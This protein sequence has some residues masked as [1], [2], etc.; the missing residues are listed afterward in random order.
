M[1]PAVFRPAPCALDARRVPLKAAGA[2]VRYQGL[3]LLTGL[4][5]KIVRYLP[6]EDLVQSHLLDLLNSKPGR[7][8]KEVTTFKLHY[9]KRG[10]LIEL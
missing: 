8:S 9:A 1:L 4:V 3:F 5:L 10:Y 6:W 2:K 7:T